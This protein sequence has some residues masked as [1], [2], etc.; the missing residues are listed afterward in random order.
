[1]L[2]TPLGAVK[3]IVNG[4]EIDFTAIKTDNL[5]L[6]CPNLNGRFLIQY[7]YKS[8]FNDQEI[9]CRIPSINVKREIESGER[10]EAISFYK[11]DIKLT[12]GVE[13]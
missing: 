13:G 6:Y 10:Y 4:E 5:K 7:D 12:I 2:L 11:N 8:E 9:K 1:M 3:L